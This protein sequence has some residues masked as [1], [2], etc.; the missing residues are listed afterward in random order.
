MTSKMFCKN[1]AVLS[2][3]AAATTDFSRA[4]VSMTK[5]AKG[6]T[7]S[8]EWTSTLRIKGLKMRIDTRVNGDNH[9][10]I[11]DLDSGK[12][13]R[14]DPKHKQVVVVDLKFASE[15]IKGGFL[16]DKLTRVV[17]ETG[18]Q[19]EI[20]GI[21]CDEYS[22][23]MQAPTAPSHRGTFVQHD[24]GTVCVSQTIPEGIEV[25]NFVLE[26]KKRGYTVAIG[27]LSPGQSAIG[28]YFF[29]QQPNVMVLAASSE[30]KV[31]GPQLGVRTYVT[32]TFTM[33]DIKSDSI[34]DEDFQIPPDW[35]QK[36]GSAFR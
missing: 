9:V 27:A 25:T 4:D 21:S 20:G 2:I 8:G 1:L 3:F 22:F 28:P 30:S 11:Y 32:G 10:S 5:H 6:G 12:W 29:G 33:S 17:K 19:R 18:K 14:L 31:N 24:S 16:P 15:H 13:Y 34:P 7:V 23:D 35:K 26:A 36:T